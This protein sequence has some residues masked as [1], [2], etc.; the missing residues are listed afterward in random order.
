[1]PDT[2]RDEERGRCLVVLGFMATGK[3]T[4]GKLA[5][6]ALGFEFIDVDQVIEAREG[7]PVTEIFRLKGE[8]YFRG[9]EHESIV[10]LAGREHAVVAPGGGAIVAARNLKPLRRL[11]FMCNL[12]AT[13]EEILRRIGDDQT[14]PLLQ[15]PDPMGRIRRLCEERAPHYAQADFTVNTTHKDVHTLAQM[16]VVR[17]H[18]WII[19]RQRAAGASGMP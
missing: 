18:M 6:R 19:D 5:A 1:M 13:P 17:Y 10:E 12:D 3:T 8:D 15:H 4:V 14:R 2:A 11:G 7:M 16:L 9:L